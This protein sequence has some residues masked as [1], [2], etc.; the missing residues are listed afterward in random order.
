[1]ARTPSAPTLRDLPYGLPKPG[2]T[3][4]RDLDSS[5][6][7]RPRARYYRRAECGWTRPETSVSARRLRRGHWKCSER[8]TRLTFAPRLT[9]RALTQDHLSRYGMRVEPWQ[10]L[11]PC[12]SVTP[13]ASSR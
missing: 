7:L 5:F 8:E 9:T 6:R 11:R 13:W 2:R 4:L 10:L 12:S 3:P 1:M